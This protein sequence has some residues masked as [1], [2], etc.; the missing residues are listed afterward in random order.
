MKICVAG[1]GA[2]GVKHLEALRSIP[3]IEVA[4][5]AG[6]SPDTTKAVAEKFAIPHLSLDLGECPLEVSFVSDRSDVHLL[7][8]DLLCRIRRGF[9]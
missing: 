2:F 6:G 1:Q 3:G 5:L 9:R 8:P 4:T 7:S